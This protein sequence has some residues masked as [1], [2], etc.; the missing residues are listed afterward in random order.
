MSSAINTSIKAS[1]TV[2]TT[3][4]TNQD[5]QLEQSI[6]MLSTDIPA[7]IEGAETRLMHR[8]DGQDTLLEDAAQQHYVQTLYLQDQAQDVLRSRLLDAL[9]FPEM[10][11]RRNTIEGRVVDFGETYSWIFDPAGEGKARSHG[12]KPH[13]FVKWLR[14]GQEVF[15]ISGKP[16]SGKSSLMDYIYQNLQPRG[17][18]FAHLEAWANRRPVRLLSFWF[19]RPATSVLL[20]SLEGFWRSLCFQILDIDQDIAAKIRAN[21]DRAAPNSLRACLVKA[22]SHAQSWTNIELRSWLRYLLDHSAFNY[23]I[24][25]DGLDEVPNDHEALLDAIRFIAQGSN[26]IKIC[27]SSRPEALFQHAFQQCPSLRLQDFNYRDIMAHCSERLSATRCASFE[28]KIADRADGVFLWAYLVVEELRRAAIQGDDEDDLERRLEE[29]PSGMNELFTFL[30]ERQDTFYAKHPKSYLRLI[31]VTVRN[32]LG[33]LSLLEVFVASQEPEMLSCNFPDNLNAQ[34]LARLDAMAENFEA[35]AVVRCAGLVEVS[36]QDIDGYFPETFPYKALDRVH[37]LRAGFIHRSAQDFLVDSE[38]GAALLQACGISELEAL[39]RVM[40]ARSVIFLVNDNSSSDASIL[41][42]ARQIKGASWTGFDSEVIDHTL[43]TVLKR[44]PRVFP[45]PL[46][47]NKHSNVSHVNHVDGEDLLCEGLVCPLLSPLQNIVFICCLQFGLT[48]YL[49][50]KLGVLEQEELTLVAGFCASLLLDLDRGG[51]WPDGAD[52]DYEILAMLKPHLSW[53]LNLTLC[54]YWPG[55]DFYLYVSRPFWQHIR[56]YS[57]KGFGNDTALK[58]LRCQLEALDVSGSY[59]TG[60][61]L[62]LRAW[63]VAEDLQLVCTEP[64]ESTALVVSTL[65]KDFDIFKINI[66]LEPSA[67]GVQFYQCSPRGLERFL[68]I[69]SSTS[70]SL[71]KAFSESPSPFPDSAAECIADILNR[72]IASLTA[73]EIAGIVLSHREWGIHHCT[74]SDGQFHAVFY[75]SWLAWKRRL[76]DGVLD[77]DFDADPEHDPILNEILKALEEEKTRR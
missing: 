14:T 48:P 18:G 8:F 23:C 19:F 11:E 7:T 66:I 69:D 56:A 44:T 32:K 37:R 55:A 30:I 76:M 35:N 5:V 27:C 13:M 1:E 34:F 26:K 73:V 65:A 33:P 47:E 40:T 71:H 39:R 6:R 17:H 72:R 50:G 53:T 61:A 64:D 60:Q 20:K 25:V 12:K 2:L 10:N 16:G 62:H 59:S 67:P 63:F 68:E 45:P 70:E 74:F 38:R 31:E 41:R 52:Y 22:G 3:R 9:A 4:L 75:D 54:H 21:V 42:A 29:C 57:G 46:T 28:M 24:L 49:K 43:R 36:E 77:Q 51:F 15:W 58:A